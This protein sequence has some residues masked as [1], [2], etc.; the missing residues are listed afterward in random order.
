MTCLKGG[1]E[2]ELVYAG[3][4]IHAPE[5]NWDDIK[6]MDLKGKALLVEVNEPGNYPGGDFDGE[7]MT[8]YGRWVYK[9]EKAAELGAAGVL[10]IHNT[11]G[12]AYGWDVVRNSWSQESFFLS[13]KEDK[14]FFRGWIHADAAETL[15]SAA[16]LSR[17][18]IKASAEQP[19]FKPHHLGL[20][21]RVRQRPSFR[22]VFAENV[23]GILRGTHKGHQ[24][25]YVILSAHFDHLG[26]DPH[27]EGDQIYNGAVDNCSA[28]AA[29]LSL[30]RYYAAKPEDL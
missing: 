6:S 30:A 8:Y 23:A 20:T 10:I 9:F 27:L 14:L 12:A 5:R 24:E 25:R 28:S 18:E 19:D 16:G 17:E 1:V 11:K 29:M 2:A 22:S 21:L 4:L 26:R 15:L 7:D 13:D 3:Y